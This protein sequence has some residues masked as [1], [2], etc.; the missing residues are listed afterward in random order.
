MKICFLVLFVL[1]NGAITVVFAQQKS[2]A[3]PTYEKN[4]I[5][6][7]IIKMF[8]GMRAGDSAMVRSVLA[9][10]ARLVSI[11][12]NQDGITQTHET[13][14]GQF[15]TAIGSPHAEVWD[16][17]ISN[18]KAEVDGDLGTY[19]CQYAFYVGNKFSHCGVDA[20]QLIRTPKGWRI[21][22]VADTRRKD[23]CQVAAVPAK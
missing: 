14:F 6:A 16:E 11:G 7:T 2:G 5:A 12:T 8:D 21:F 15:L 22:Q 13:P 3:I 17:R 20:F 23:N 1:G 4:A 10:G 18:G 19:W 9:P